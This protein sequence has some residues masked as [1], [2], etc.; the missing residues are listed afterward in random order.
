V[1]DVI[2]KENESA[3]KG[4]KCGAVRIPAIKVS[5]EKEPAGMT[6][7]RTKKPRKREA[8]EVFMYPL[9]ISPRERLRRWG[10]NLRKNRSPGKHQRR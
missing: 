4:T 5:G 10:R 9:K 7:R 6:G 8:Y 1:I 3:C 2:I